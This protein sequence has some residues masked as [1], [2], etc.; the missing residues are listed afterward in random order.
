[1][2]LGDGMS[3]RGEGE[4][5]GGEDGGSNERSLLL[6]KL[7]II[8]CDPESE[9]SQWRMPFL[10]AGLSRHPLLSRAIWALGPELGPKAPGIISGE[11]A[12]NLWNSLILLNKK[13][14]FQC[15]GF[16][17]RWNVVGNLAKM[18]MLILRKELCSFPAFWVLKN[19]ELNRNYLGYNWVG[20]T[21]FAPKTESS[22]ATKEGTDS[23]WHCIRGGFFLLCSLDHLH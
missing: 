17:N 1:M 7:R 5:R 3:G 19:I 13:W 18:S 2:C 14:T 23:S 15:V 16:Y 10:A 20:C 6:S 9:L 22:L 21:K 11:W 12:Q 4:G 8:T